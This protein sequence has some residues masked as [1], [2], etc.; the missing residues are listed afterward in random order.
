MW[1]VFMSTKIFA[2]KYPLAEMRFHHISFD[3]PSYEGVEGSV[4]DFSVETNLSFGVDV[5]DLFCTLSVSAKLTPSNKDTVE[6]GDVTEISIEVTGTARFELE[7]GHDIT[8]ARLNNLSP[9]EVASFSNCLDPLVM[10]KV[11]TILA[12]A[13]IEGVTIPLQLRPTKSIKRSK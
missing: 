3:L 10:S 12:D 5:E 9:E 4:G 13:G 2:Y 1:G 7:E 11:K 8:E 6:A